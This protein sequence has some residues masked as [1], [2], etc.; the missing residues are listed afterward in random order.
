MQPPSATLD[1]TTAANR[2]LRRKLDSDVRED[3][4][5]FDIV[6]HVDL[7]L[8]VGTR[9]IEVA[10]TILDVPVIR[11]VLNIEEQGDVA[12][13]RRPRSVDA[14]VELP[15]HRQSRQDFARLLGRL[16]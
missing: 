9:V 12:P 4:E 2:S 13:L 11:D 15:E 8:E 1:A 14:D 6:V 7:I 3:R 10:V 5:A 16:W